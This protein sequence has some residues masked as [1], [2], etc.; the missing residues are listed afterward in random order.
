MNAE[1]PIASAGYDDGYFVVRDGLKLHYR[2]YAG[3]S[4]RPPIACRANTT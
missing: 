2:D 3:A 4:D 1:G